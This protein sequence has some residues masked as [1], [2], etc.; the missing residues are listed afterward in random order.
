[1]KRLPITGKQQRLSGMNDGFDGKYHL[2]LCQVFR[3]IVTVVPHV[4]TPEHQ[5]KPQLSRHIVSASAFQ[6]SEST[7]ST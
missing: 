4:P 5:S 3:S 7:E 6:S 2:Q 1:M